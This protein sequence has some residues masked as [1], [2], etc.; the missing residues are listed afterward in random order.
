MTTYMRFFK[1]EGGDIVDLPSPQDIM[2][3]GSAGLDVVIAEAVECGALEADA[4]EYFDKLVLNQKRTLMVR[5]VERLIQRAEQVSREEA[6]A[7][8]RDIL[9]LA[10]QYLWSAPSD[11]DNAKLETARDILRREDGRK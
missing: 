1:V 4:P 6:I 5:L 11:P 3:L 8:L 7:S 2:Q 10:E 9:P